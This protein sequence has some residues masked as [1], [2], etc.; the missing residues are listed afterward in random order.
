MWHNLGKITDIPKNTGRTFSLGTAS[1]A[2]FN[3][4]GKFYAMQNACI[5]R[6]GPLGEG[7]LVSGRVT[8]PWHAWEFDVKTGACSTLKGATQKTYPTKTKN[9]EVFVEV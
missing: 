8:C 3:L 4:G 2:L 1:I 6:G 9:Q 7:S 5:H